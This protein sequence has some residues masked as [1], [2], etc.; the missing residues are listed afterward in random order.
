[1]TRKVECCQNSNDGDRVFP[2]K[3]MRF[4]LR[5]DSFE[6]FGHITRNDVDMLRGMA[7]KT[8]CTVTDRGGAVLFDPLQNR[9]SDVS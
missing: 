7:G 9:E 1:M 8:E 5:L 2:I 6:K 3:E 4:Y